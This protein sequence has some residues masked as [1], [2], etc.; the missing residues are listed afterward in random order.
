M[1][2]RILAL[3]I[4]AP[5]L[6]LAAIPVGLAANST[7]LAPDYT[8][9]TLHELR[10]IKPS[11]PN[12]Y[13]S[14]LPPGVTPDWEYWRT[15]LR[16]EGVARQQRMATVRLAPLITV[17][18]LEPNDTQAT[19]NFITGFGTGEGDDPEADITGFVAVPP[20][21]RVIIPNTEDEGSIPLATDTGVLTG[22]GVIA[23]AF[24]GDG[25]HAS[26]GTGTGDFDFYK[27]PNVI[28][29]QVI[30]VFVDTPDPASMLAPYLV[31]YASNGTVVASS[32]F[33][34]IAGGV[35]QITM[36][37]PAADDYFVSV[38]SSGSFSLT[39]PFDSA[40]GP[41]VGSEGSYTIQIDLDSE[42][43][44]Y[45]SMTLEAG[46]ILGA[47][48]NGAATEIAL[49]D[50]GGT[51][52]I[53]SLQ[54]LSFLYPTAS[55]LPG[56]GNGVYA[57]VIEQA[58]D[59]A[60]RVG[61][62]PGIYSLMLR[63]FRS[64]LL[65]AP[66]GSVQTLFVDFDGAVIDPAIFN[67]PPGQATL[68]PLATFL[69][70]WGLGAADED[71]VIDA[72]LGAIEESLSSDVRLIGNNGDF[73]TTGGSGQFD[74]VILNS[75]D[76]ADPFGAPN[77][78]RII[79][80][81]TIDELDIITIGIAQSIDPG[82]FETRESGV[83]LLDFLSAPASNPGSINS[84]ALEAGASIIDFI[85]IGVGN[86]AVHEAGHIFG[87]F[88]TISNNAVA[89]IMDVG[90]NQANIFGVG[91]D[92][93]FG[94]ADDIDVDL[95]RDDYYDVFGDFEGVEDTLN[96]VAF[97]LPTPEFDDGDGD[98]VADELDQCLATPLLPTTVKIGSCDSGLPDQLLGEPTGCSI[99][100]EILKLAEGAKSHGQFVSRVDKFLLQLQKAGILM[101]QQK[102]EIKQC[103]AHS[104]LP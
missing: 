5:L 94:S 20:T 49:F 61:G 99:T 43:V 92:Q 14:F 1:K 91:D 73:A 51:L 23:S 74:I 57:Y 88:H 16:L 8:S 104:D 39:D 44:D 71:A 62:D 6:V 27:I 59:Y 18:D 13:L 60:V 69:P 24:R 19:A 11:T 17:S 41:G 52:R 38:G 65:A 79:I 97:D 9:M 83:V 48:L 77:V 15:R 78:S 101:P 56:G 66:L 103:V 81:G 45:F 22:E 76:H 50:P 89:N 70:G 55:P 29:A 90:G 58:G 35:N 4:L 93:T 82:N 46:D 54:D 67:E 63:A 32:R 3:P 86:I 10:Q 2:Y 31:I 72:I 102:D 25:P 47:S 84:F 68:S 75:R 95:G 36:L 98:G 64:P 40:D 42:D 96:T 28:A 100:D 87:N 85:G 37:A 12:P 33:L 34:S 26:S 21:P 53:A 80:G 7:A 30:N